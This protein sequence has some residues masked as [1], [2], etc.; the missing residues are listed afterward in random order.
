MH[1]DLAPFIKNLLYRYD[2]VILPGF[3][4][5]ITSYQSAHFHP[6]THT[7]FPPSKK[8]GFNSQL[9]LNDGLLATEISFHF[10][11]SQEAA[12][13]KVAKYIAELRHAINSGGT[14]DL[15]EIG[16]FKLNE[17]GNIRFIPAEKINFFT[18]SFGMGTFRSPAILRPTDSVAEVKEKV[19]ELPRAVGSRQWLRV[20]AVAVPLIALSAFGIWAK[21][22]LANSYRQYS[23]LKLTTE[24]A[25]KRYEERGKAIETATEEDHF[26]FVN[27]FRADEVVNEEST[28]EPSAPLVEEAPMEERKNYEATGTMFHIIAGCFSI[29]R[30]AENLVSDLRNQGFNANIV[31]TNPSGWQLV[32]FESY[33]TREEAEKALPTIQAQHNAQAWLLKK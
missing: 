28:Y 30:N 32:A 24:T 29:E 23:Y 33:S 19:K 26:S 11:I 18:D 15:Q 1:L 31:G 8:M 3:G 20:A 10:K 5:F 21:D 14:F 7:F 25:Q 16:R 12:Q 17:E 27:Y 4:G 6:V 9:T 22:P 13:E 2:C